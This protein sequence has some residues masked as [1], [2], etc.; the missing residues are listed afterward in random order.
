MVLG[1]QFPE[2]LVEQVRAFRHALTM[3][4]VGLRSLFAHH[5]YHCHQKRLKQHLDYLVGL[6][7]GLIDAGLEQVEIGLDSADALNGDGCLKKLFHWQVL[8]GTLQGIVG[9][10]S[11]H[12]G[13]DED[14]VCLKVLGTLELDDV[15]GHVDQDARAAHCVLLEVDYIVE[16]ATRAD[17]DGHCVDAAWL[18]KKILPGNVVEDDHLA[19]VVNQILAAKHAKLVDCYLIQLHLSD[20]FCA[21]VSEKGKIGK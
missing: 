7:H 2:T 9:E 14:G 20:V 15:L 19:F 11:Y 13:R 4:G 8:A 18:L 6:L 12:V 1:E 3:V 17:Q 21:K 16:R 5:A 10:G